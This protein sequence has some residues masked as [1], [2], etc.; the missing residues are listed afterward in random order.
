MP[1]QIFVHIDDVDHSAARPDTFV[2]DAPLVCR[3]FLGRNPGFRKIT[4][5]EYTTLCAARL[6]TPFT[7][8]THFPWGSVP[9]DAGVVYV[10]RQAQCA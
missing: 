2:L 3:R 8:S 1:K 7:A 6:G 4:H 5:T 10:R 9:P